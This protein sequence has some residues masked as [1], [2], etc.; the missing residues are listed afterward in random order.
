MACKYTSLYHPPPQYLYYKLTDPLGPSHSSCSVSAAKYSCPRCNILYCSVH[1]YKAPD[2]SQCSEPFYRECVMAEMASGN[3]ADN[4]EAAA[5]KKR[6]YE[7]LMRMQSVESNASDISDIDLTEQIRQLEDLQEVQ[8]ED[9]DDDNNSEL[10]SDDEAGE[11]ATETL[12]CNDLAERLQDVDLNDANAVWQKLT[13]DE[14][15]DFEQLVQTGDISA[16]VPEYEP[17]WIVAAPLLIEE[18]VVSQADNNDGG[19]NN[20]LVAH[21]TK[22]QLPQLLENIKRFGELSTT[23]S[24]DP[25]VRHN[26]VNILAAYTFAARF[27]NGDHQSYPHESAHCLVSICANIKANWNYDSDAAALESVAMQARNEGLRFD[28]ADVQAMRSDVE[29][30]LH[31]PQ[32]A[33][34]QQREVIKDLEILEQN[35]FILTAL[36]DLYRVLMQAKL[37]KDSPLREKYSPGVFHKRFA[38]HEINNFGELKRSKLGVYLKKIEYF[39]AYS[40]QFV[41]G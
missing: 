13:A 5:A 29:K 27:F 10:D 4:Q 8:E 19:D 40:N 14:Q 33:V 9:D 7:M 28:E 17:W 6:M 18:V 41:L 23:K 30:L 20:R 22:L 26:L 36:S 34:V 16:I 21:E 24:P 12:Q 35:L 2:H 3:A 37:Q 11:T 31:P 32:H 38:D 15:K 39:L 1:C 25:C